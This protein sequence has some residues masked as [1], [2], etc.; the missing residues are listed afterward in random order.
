MKVI[1]I[2]YTPRATSGE[3]KCKNDCVA[4]RTAMALTNTNAPSATASA[5]CFILTKGALRFFSNLGGRLL[6]YNC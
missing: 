4:K 5:I 6:G 1:A 3:M 2:R